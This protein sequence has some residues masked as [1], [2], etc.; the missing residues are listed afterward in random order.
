MPVHS[1]S[2]AGLLV[3]GGLALAL[4]GGLV[5]VVMLAA[6]QRTRPL[7]IG[8]LVA[9]VLA[10]PV[11]LAAVWLFAAKGAAHQAKWAEQEAASRAMDEQAAFEASRRIELQTASVTTPEAS[12]GPA[13]KAGTAKA[14]AE[15]QGRLLPAVGRSIVQS[16]GEL[17][18]SPAPRPARQTTTVIEATAK[19]IGQSLA[20]DRKRPEPAPAEK[21][22]SKPPEEKPTPPAESELTTTEI[23]RADFERWL[24]SRSDAAVAQLRAEFEGW[25]AAG[26]HAPPAATTPAAP[27]P[28]WVDAEPGLVDGDYQTKVMVGP[29]ATEEECDEALTPALQQAVSDYAER[30]L[31]SGGSRGLRITPDLRQ[32]LVAQVWEDVQMTD[33]GPEIGPKPMIRRYAL[34]RFAHGVKDEIRAQHRAAVVEKRLWFL[35]YG[36]A[37]VLG[38]LGLTFA[39]LKTSMARHRPS[40]TET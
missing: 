35:G 37:G 27:R 30:Y 3:L 34:L 40:G 14:Q 25:L 22:A 11:L 19:A 12:P 26:G 17:R 15:K 38:L 24:A 31:G 33:F 8:L 5:L 39:Y 29:Y 2:F 1:V 16:A 10:C 4:L 20:R 32:H 21:P 36:M 7:G 6:H 13:A 9:G 23:L 18:V 28:A